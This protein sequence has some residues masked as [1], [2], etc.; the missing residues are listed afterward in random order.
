MVLGTG[1][2]YWLPCIRGGAV[3]AASMIRAM[4]GKLILTLWPA[5]DPYL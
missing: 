4:A 5:K 2:H 3:I 1:R